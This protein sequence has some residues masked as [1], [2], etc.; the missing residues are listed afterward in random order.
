M[1]GFTKTGL[2]LYLWE[3]IE[4]DG[5]QTQDGKYKDPRFC[6]QTLKKFY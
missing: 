2:K 4:W 6:L 1:P 5:R 3:G